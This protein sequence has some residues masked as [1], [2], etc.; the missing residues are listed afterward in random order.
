MVVHISHM[1]VMQPRSPTLLSSM[2]VLR[3]SI[4]MGSMS[5]SKTIHLGDSLGLLERSLMM[6]DNR[7]A[8]KQQ[9]K[10]IAMVSGRILFSTVA[11]IR[12]HLECLSYR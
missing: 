10:I 12:S 11:P 5:P 4:H 6:Q 3:D 2:T 8:Q 1:Q 9:V 7:P